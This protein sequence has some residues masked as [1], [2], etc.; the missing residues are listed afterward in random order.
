ML[1]LTGNKNQSFTADGSKFIESTIKFCEQ[2]YLYCRL[3]FFVNLLVLQYLVQYTH[4]VLILS[5]LTF[6]LLRAY[7]LYMQYLQYS[8]MLS[9]L[10]SGHVV[11]LL[12]VCTQGSHSTWKTWKSGDSFYHGKIRRNLE[13]WEFQLL[14]IHFLKF[15]F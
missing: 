2:L 9:L 3:D 7:Y 5:V 12:L 6:M 8:A 13:K 15:F 14:L 1:F 10:N 4:T 11:K